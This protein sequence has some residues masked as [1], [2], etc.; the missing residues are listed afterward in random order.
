[1]VWFFLLMATRLHS[2][3]ANKDFTYLIHTVDLLKVFVALDSFYKDLGLL[4]QNS[5]GNKF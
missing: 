2:F 5:R 4:L 3:G 1:M